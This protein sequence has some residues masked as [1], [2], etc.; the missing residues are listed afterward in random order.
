MAQDNKNVIKQSLLGNL[1]SYL[2]HP[3]Y[4]IKPIQKKAGVK[5]ID[6]F[7]LWSLGIVV[8]IV[9]GIIIFKATQ[10]VGY[11]LA[12][13]S[14]VNQFLEKPW[15]LI[16]FVIFIWAPITEELT[17][18]MGLKYSPYRL[19]FT[20]AFLLV[21]ILDILLR[22]SGDWFTNLI[23][24]L[25]NQTK[26]AGII[27]YLC[28]IISVGLILGKYLKQK[29]IQQQVKQFYQK[30]F[31]KIFY[32]VAV[33]FAAVHIFNYYNLGQIWYLVFFWLYLNLFLA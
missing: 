26:Y 4:Y 24:W 23:N 1:L 12:E 6:I 9:L 13:N 28:F 21:I 7:K 2:Q 10:A 29:L 25:F 31:T 17:F 16:V 11:N 18:R 20:C 15:Y 5:F 32:L 22:F 14:L 30:N 19:S 27:F 3:S 8:A 33:I